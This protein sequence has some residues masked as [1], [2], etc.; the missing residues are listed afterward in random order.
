MQTVIGTAKRFV[1]EGRNP[2]LADGSLPRPNAR[3]QFSDPEPRTS[4]PFCNRIA[5]S[6]LERSP[7]DES[8]V[9]RKPYSNALA[10]RRTSKIASG[11]DS[12]RP[13]YGRVFPRILVW[14]FL[15][16]G[17][18]AMA[19]SE[20]TLETIDETS[21]IPVPARIEFLKS[22][23]R[24]K[25]DRKVPSVGDTWLSEESLVLQPMTGDFEF[26]ALRGP[27]FKEIRGGFTIEGR[28]KDSVAI[29]IPRAI[30]MHAEEWFSGD[31][32]C[33][34]DPQQSWRWQVADAI[35]MVVESSLAISKTAVNKKQDSARSR[36]ASS[37]APAPSDP[38]LVGHRWQSY[39][40]EVRL[41]EIGFAVHRNPAPEKSE[42]ADR[43]VPGEGNRSSKF[44]DAI[45][46]LE[47]SLGEPN[48]LIEITQLAARDVPLMLAHPRVK[49]AR[50]LNSCNR[51]K[52]DD[53]VSHPKRESP[54]EFARIMATFGKEKQTVSLFA[55]IDE[56]E[57]IRFKS[58]RAAG[59][60]AEYL[61]WQML[62]AGLRLV[63][64]AASG[65]GRVDTNLGYNRIYAYCDSEKT[66][67]GWWKGV[68][69]GSVFVTNGPLLRTLI[70]GV[71][72]GAVQAVYD[73]EPLPLSI[74]VS[75]AVREPVDYLDVVFNGETL[76]SAKLEEHYRKGEFPEITIDKSGWL[77]IRVITEHEEGYR[78]ATTAPFYYEVDGK[79]RISRRA[80]EFFQAWLARSVAR[81]EQD[82]TL[83]SDY[84]TSIER[85][86]QFW[87]DR[88][89]QA[90]AP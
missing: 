2:Q 22:A 84:R 31:L 54:E 80:V 70:N 7:L 62:E 38:D 29:E 87:A 18:Q 47:E 79:P 42:K 32:S 33:E 28:S 55:P 3:C 72:P 30:D 11:V 19:Q 44:L 21:G 61:Y 75:L 74:A 71:P 88:L 13:Q 26:L 82:E 63:P 9:K 12:F 1:P 81:I 83:A 57:R 45:R 35:D 8:S 68:E 49:L 5:N 86:Q 10:T 39:C 65:F 25:V 64:T 59:M 27:E 51:P 48:A 6:L 69:S 90:N 56:K 17:S 24:L 43:E 37:P 4:V 16:C 50:V 67:E 76:Y 40:K 20:V 36:K 34:W 78:M 15:F 52:K 53:V 89:E 58:A 73:G 41:P 85:A 66:P 23:K 77:V 46:V 14:L 60:L